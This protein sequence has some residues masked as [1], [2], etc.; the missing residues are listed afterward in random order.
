MRKLILCILFSVFC[1]NAAP[2]SDAEKNEMKCLTLNIYFEARNQSNEGQK[3]VGFVTL[4]RTLSPRF[5]NT[6]CKVIYQRK[7]FSWYSDGKPDVPTNTKAWK[8]AM[9][10]AAFV[11]NNY[12]RDNTRGALF[13]H[14]DYVS[15]MW[16]KSL[17]VKAIIQKHIF[18]AYP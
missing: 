9:M 13:Y 5:P 12:H 6:I 18:Y 3:A 15:P 16:S 7:Q 4:N 14:A 2:V 10:N 1:I 8:R 17:K 11:V